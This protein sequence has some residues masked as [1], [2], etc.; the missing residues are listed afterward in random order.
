[1]RNAAFFSRF[2]ATRKIERIISCAAA[3]VGKFQNLCVHFCSV[4]LFARFVVVAVLQSELCNRA[5]N[6]RNYA[7]SIFACAQTRRTRLSLIQFFCTFHWNENL[8]SITLLLKSKRSPSEFPVLPVKHTKK[9]VKYNAWRE[10]VIYVCYV[11]G[12]LECAHIELGGLANTRMLH[13]LPDRAIVGSTQVS[14][15]AQLSESNLIKIERRATARQSARGGL[16]ASVFD[17]VRLHLM[18]GIFCANSLDV[19]FPRRLVCAS[20]RWICGM[21]A[22]FCPPLCV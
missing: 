17:S 3:S 22:I 9:K 10:C 6:S 13:K 19:F 7:C 12:V 21:W 2:P 20:I 16:P 18:P 8:H 4:L 14:H 5:K 15:S 11:I 1:M